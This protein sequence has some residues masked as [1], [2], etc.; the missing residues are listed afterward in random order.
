MI[1][2]DTAFT[3]VVY[4]GLDTAPIIYFIEAHPQYNALVTS[5]FQRI[6]DG[7]LRAC[8]S[9]ISLTEVLIHPIRQGNAVLQQQYQELFLNSQGFETQNI[10]PDTAILAADLRARYNLRTPDALQIAT[11]L[12]SGC[13]AFLTNDTTLKRV[14]ELTVLVLS[15]IEL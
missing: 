10:N 4:L 1:K 13:Q 6:A 14:T 11:A 8:T 3:G 15:E 2:L 12:Q 9:V 7:T 5:I